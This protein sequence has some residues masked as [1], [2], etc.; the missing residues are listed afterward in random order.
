MVVVSVVAGICFR[1]AGF[2]TIV[3]GLSYI[4][5]AVMIGGWLHLKYFLYH[6]KCLVCN[7]KVKT[8]KNSAKSKLV[9]VCKDCQ[10][11]WDLQTEID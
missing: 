5:A 6:V 10:I 1:W 8:T 9:A 3:M 7:S 2:E 11:E 4:C